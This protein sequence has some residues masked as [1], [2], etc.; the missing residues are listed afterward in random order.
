MARWTTKDDN[1]PTKTVEAECDGSKEEENEGYDSDRGYN[2]LSKMLLRE[3]RERQNRSN[4]GSD[5]EKAN[6]GEMGYKDFKTATLKRV[7]MREIR[8]IGDNKIRAVWQREQ[9]V[10]L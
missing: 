1:T 4:D 6:E 10:I 5:V 8:K 7:Y 9:G 3:E 2:F